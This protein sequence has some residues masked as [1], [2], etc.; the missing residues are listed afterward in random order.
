MGDL[1]AD[2]RGRTGAWTR[3]RL[4]NSAS[5][6]EGLSTY[7]QWNAHN[8]GAFAAGQELELALSWPSVLSRPHLRLSSPSRTDIIV[9]SPVQSRPLCR[10]IAF[11]KWPPILSRD[12]SPLE[13]IPLRF[14]SHS[15]AYDRVHS[16]ALSWNCSGP[17]HAI[18]RG[19]FRVTLG[20]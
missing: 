14:K 18:R 5:Q 12:S 8:R 4:P 17:S 16:I 7:V 13:R 9:P 3:A 15:C 10:S 6:R 2:G 11:G 20:G 1:Q 19:T